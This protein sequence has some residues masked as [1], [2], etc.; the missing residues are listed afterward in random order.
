MPKGSPQDTKTLVVNLPIILQNTP[1][2]QKIAA[3][4]PAEVSMFLDLDRE[5]I[6]RLT[7]RFFNV[8]PKPSA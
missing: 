6:D 7:K 1:H 8:M 4:D 3:V 2:G 5:A